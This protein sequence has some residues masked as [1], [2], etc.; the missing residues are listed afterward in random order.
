MVELHI[1]QSVVL[2]SKEA[3]VGL[4]EAI[5]G[6]KALEVR[7]KGVPNHA[8]ATP[9]NLRQDPMVGA[10]H[11]ISLIET[12]AKGSGTEST[13]ATVG[14]IQCRP[15]VSNIIPGEV[16]FSVDIRDAI[17]SGIDSVLDG[18]AAVGPAIALAR[19]LVL[20]TIP[21][22]ESAPVHLDGGILSLI[23]RC[24]AR[25]GMSYHRMNS[26]AVHDSCMLA[27]IVP[28]GMIFIPS[29]G[30]RSHVPEEYTSP[31]EIAKGTSLLAEVLL[32]LAR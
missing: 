4:V 19:G 16:I 13:V 2:E 23:E 8:G 15:N 26:G 21:I 25:L 29:R 31:E 1:E 6:I 27:P 30:G 17:Q 24:A 28:T 3:A 20:E 12:L 32:E 5:A 22:S 18:I 11:L 10:A 14:K 7:L 9:M